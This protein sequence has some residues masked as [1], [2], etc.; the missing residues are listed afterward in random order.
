L[1]RNSG[2]ALIAGVVVAVVGAVVTPLATVTVDKLTEE[3]RPPGCP[4]EGCDG[5][6]PKD[7]GCTDAATY[8]RT[9]D[10]PADLQI[11]YSKMC[12]AAWGRILAGNPGDSVTV[13]ADG[14]SVKEAEISVDHDQFTRMAGIADSRAFHVRVCAIPASDPDRKDTWQRYCIDATDATNW[15]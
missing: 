4:G 6:N 7:E 3:N 11:R 14:G 9:R 15:R 12:H 8:E 5:R 13:Q 10:N 2:N 1:R